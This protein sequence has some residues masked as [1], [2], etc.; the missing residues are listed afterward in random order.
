MTPTRCPGC[1]AVLTLS[2]DGWS[3][4]RLV[5]HPRMGVSVSGPEWLRRARDGRLP[6]KVYR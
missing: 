5:E 4:H 3:W 2:A 1:G 6:A